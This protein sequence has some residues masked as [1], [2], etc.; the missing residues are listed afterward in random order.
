[1]D[2]CE[3]VEKEIDRVV[4]KFT[5]VKGD[6]IETINEIIS[7]LSVCLNS[8][9]LYSLFTLRDGNFLYSVLVLGT[10]DRSSS[11][12]TEQTIEL[13]N[14]IKRCKTKL[15][16]IG[17]EHRNLHASVSKVG[18]AIDRHFVPDCQSIAP[19]D[20]CE[21]AQFQ[22][23]LTQVIAE[24][25]NRQGMTDVADSLAEESR[26]S[27]EQDIHL[28]LFADLYQMWESINHR[29]LGPAI[30]WVTQYCSELQTRKSSLE[31]KLH[32]L[33]YLQLLEKG[34]PAQAEAIAYSRAHF[35]KFMGRFDKEIQALM[36]CLIYVPM[37]YEN[38]V[39]S[40]LF[41]N[42]MWVDAADSFL[43]ESC[44][45]IGVNRDSC[46]EIIVNSGIYALP[47]LLNLKQ[48]MVK[49]AVSG[50]WSGRNE[51]PIEIDLGP[52]HRY[53]ST[54]TCPILK[55]PSTDQNPPMK[56]KCGHVISKDAMHKLTRG[57]ML[58][59]PYCPKESTVSET[60]KI[61]F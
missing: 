39:Y 24:H 26:L 58:K 46:L 37:G 27:H 14:V 23:I 59:C 7:V 61:Y 6:S 36:G 17:V 52:E 25:F 35:N 54:F 21:S 57:L 51:L 40:S 47:S 34:I 29:N 10:M 60:K 49:N 8:L 56:L 48:I 1:M 30:E 43:R 4:K 9:G 16:K 42:E 44:E 32:R 33:V 11:L 20:L 45:L 53:H 38:T 41:S 55:Q 19:L 5:D 28:E 13:K 12:S 2:S 15:Q 31:F 50:V 3:A 22:G 18:K